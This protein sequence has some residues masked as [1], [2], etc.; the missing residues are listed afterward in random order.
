MSRTHDGAID[1]WLDELARYETVSGFTY[2]F[3]ELVAQ[4]L[5]GVDAPSEAM[6]SLYRGYLAVEARYHGSLAAQVAGDSVDLKVVRSASEKHEIGMRSMLA[7][8]DEAV[9]F[10]AAEVGRTLVAAQCCY[11]LGLTDQV[12]DRLELAIGEG[13]GHPLVQFALGY[14]RY[15]LAAEVFTRHDATTG[16]DEV[17]DEDRFR[18]A[19]LGAVSAFQ[20]GLSGG[21]FDGQLHWWIATALRSA[22]FADAADASVRRAAEMIGDGVG[23][24]DGVS[25]Y[26]WSGEIVEGDGDPGPISDQEIEEAIA[27]F[28]RG[29]TLS[30]LD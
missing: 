2:A 30:D 12:I 8:V 21:E 14:N 7:L 15:Q 11:H 27:Q 20:D 3:Y 6:R 18:M 17:L 16:E 29:L 10:G 4:Y 1:Q 13:V 25:S 28:R 26:G 24:D 5:S 19:C 23:W 22:G 9:T